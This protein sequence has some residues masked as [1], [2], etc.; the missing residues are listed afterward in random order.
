MICR[1]AKNVTLKKQNIINE[2]TSINSFESDVIIIIRA[3]EYEFLNLNEKQ[4][5][6]YTLLNSFKSN[7]IKITFFDFSTSNL[8]NFKK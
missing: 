4:N 2:I 8:N 5:L 3:S 6:R 1:W 7:V